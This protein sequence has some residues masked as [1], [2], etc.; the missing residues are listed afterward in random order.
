H[1]PEV[2]AQYAYRL[3]EDRQALPKGF[4]ARMHAGSGQGLR[5]R[6]E[7]S[8]SR[9]PDPQIVIEGKMEVRVQH[10]YSFERF[11][12]HECRWLAYKAF[13]LESG[14]VI[15]PERG[16]ASQHGIMLIDPDTLAINY[17]CLRRGQQMAHRRADRSRQISVIGA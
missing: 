13:A 12:P 16:V 15:G 1:V 17:R 4:V 14:G 7:K 3:F 2:P 5:Q 9:Q 10:P 6:G 11:A 8:G